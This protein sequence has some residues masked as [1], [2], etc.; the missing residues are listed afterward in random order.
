MVVQSRSKEQEQIRSVFANRMRANVPDE[1]WSGDRAKLVWC[2]ANL[3][4][5]GQEGVFG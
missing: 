4:W 1:R 5:A 2:H 3:G